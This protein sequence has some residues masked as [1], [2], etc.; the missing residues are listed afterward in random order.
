MNWEVIALTRFYKVG[1]PAFVAKQQK[2]VDLAFQSGSLKYKRDITKAYNP[3]FDN[4]AVP[5]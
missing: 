2:I 5:G 1:D 4:V 3:I